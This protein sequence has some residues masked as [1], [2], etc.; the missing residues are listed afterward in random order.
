MAYPSL[1]RLGGG[2]GVYALGVY[3][4]IVLEFQLFFI[5][6]DGTH[7]SETVACNDVNMGP[8]IEAQM[9]ESVI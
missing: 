5:I 1:C 8:M 7:W 6:A 9:I 4:I 3:W 2:A